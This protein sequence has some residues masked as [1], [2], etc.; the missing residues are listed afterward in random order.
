MTCTIYGQGLLRNSNQV[1]L[2]PIWK[3]FGV[4]ICDLAMSLVDTHQIQGLLGLREIPRCI[5]ENIWEGGG[6]AIGFTDS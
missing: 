6:I 4:M 5:C 2:V 3:S 1:Q